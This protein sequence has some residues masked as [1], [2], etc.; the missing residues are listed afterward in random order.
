MIKVSEFQS[1]PSSITQACNHYMTILYGPVDLILIGL[2]V[3]V[4][5]SINS[6]RFPSGD[7]YKAFNCNLSERV[8]TQVVVAS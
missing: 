7:L 1:K 5:G 6:G 3:Y 2:H 8:L 4:H